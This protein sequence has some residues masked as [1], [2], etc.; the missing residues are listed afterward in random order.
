MPRSVRFDRFGGPEVLYVADVEVRPPSP[1]QVLIE[2]RAAGVNPV[3]G[4]IRRGEFGSPSSVFPRGLGVDAAG[5]VLATGDGVADVSPGDE[6]LGVTAGAGYAQQALLKQWTSKP[7]GLGWDVAASLPTP[8]EAAFRALK[9]LTLAPG[10][11]V[12]IHGAAGAVGSIATQLAVSRG[13]TVVGTV[14]AADDDYL[15]SL[16]GIPVRFGDGVEER[17]R[18]VAPQGV[19]AALDTAGRGALQASIELTGGTARVLTLA[20]PEAE[21]YGVTF[22]GGSPDDRAPEALAAL[23][24]L[25]ASGVLSLRIARSFALDE[26]A[27]AH[28]LLES[29]TATGKLVLLA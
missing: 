4:K 15:R 21:K 8:G 25:F 12:L 29:G 11:T 16:G 28:R 27:E 22:S 3:D 13:L 2:V 14:M 18:A 1:G 7:A 5:V 10:E 24:P 20:D 23:A 17:V 19:D 26:A 6:V 9:A